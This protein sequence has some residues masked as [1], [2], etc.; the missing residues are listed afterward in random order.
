[1]KEVKMKTSSEK[2]SSFLV[3]KK[4]FKPS[5]NSNNRKKKMKRRVKS[6]ENKGVVYLSHIPHGFYDDQIKGYFSQF[7]KVT[8]VSVPRSK[9]GRARGFAFIEFQHPEVAEIAAETMNNY[10]MFKRLLKAKYIPPKEQKPRHFIA[11]S[12]SK[13]N[14]TTLP[15]KAVKS[16]KQNQLMKNRQLKKEKEVKK[17][18]KLLKK[19]EEMSKNLEK[20]GIDYKFQ[21]QKSNIESLLVKERSSEKDKRKKEERKKE[22]KIKMSPKKKKVTSVGDEDYS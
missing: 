1:M 8:N 9:S 2:G 17:M 3:K 18:K 21:V 6:T 12:E 15:E 16:M 14:H 10:L 22:E 11:A 20:L 19:Q 7:G 13:Q 4:I 5:A